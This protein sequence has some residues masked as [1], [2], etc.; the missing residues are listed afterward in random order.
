MNLKKMIAFGIVLIIFFLIRDVYKSKSK[1]RDD[2]IIQNIRTIG[3][4]II[5]FILAI[6]LFIT[7]KSFCELFP[8]F[9]K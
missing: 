1:G 4:A 8:Y 9:C 5:F 3:A 6:S 7:K 2:L